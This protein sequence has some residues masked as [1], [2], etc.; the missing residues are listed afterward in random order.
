M[1][2]TSVAS[3]VLSCIL[4]SLQPLPLM[5]ACLAFVKPDLPDFWTSLCAHPKKLGLIQRLAL[6][7]F[8]C[9]F[10][11][12]I[13]DLGLLNSVSGHPFLLG[14][15]DLLRI[16]RLV[17]AEGAY[18]ARS[19]YRI[20]ISRSRVSTPGLLNSDQNSSMKELLIL[21]QQLRILMVEYNKLF[22]LFL[23][24]TKICFI[25]FAMFGA[26]GAFR[27]AGVLAVFLFS[28]GLFCICYLIVYIMLLGEVHERSKD[29]L[30]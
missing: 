20:F 25:S 22:H 9:Y 18:E 24:S 13:C 30:Q 26:Y 10:G 16:M 15:L 7:L 21:Y 19:F 2:L 12:L 17:Q 11:L 6:A 1:P 4:Y 14:L 27:T 23:V 29:F 3:Y 8:Q 5:L 28:V